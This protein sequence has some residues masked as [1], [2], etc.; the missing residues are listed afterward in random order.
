MAALSSTAPR[1]PALPAAP[2]PTASAASCGR[3]ARAVFA[4]MN[5]GDRMSDSFQPDLDFEA[6]QNAA[7][8]GEA[9]IVDVDGY[10]GPLHVLLALG[11]QPEGRLC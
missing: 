5:A 7:A 6:A 10:E 8:D 3:P 11:A 1:S 9:L 2:R 4:P